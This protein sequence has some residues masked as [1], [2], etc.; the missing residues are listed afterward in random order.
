M[1]QGKGKKDRAVP[2]N[3]GAEQALR[4]SLAGRDGLGPRSPLFVAERTGR[5]LSRQ[6]L[7]S[8]LGRLYTRLGIDGASVHTL[9][10]TFAT[11]SLRKGVSLLVV[12]EVLGHSSLLST[13]RYLHLL[14]ETMCAEL[15][16]H[17]L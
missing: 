1:R 10:H 3:P 16:K 2:L 9:R 17:A 4:A 5:P 7:G 15:E 12:K 14:R 11:H 13:E 8:L 6:G